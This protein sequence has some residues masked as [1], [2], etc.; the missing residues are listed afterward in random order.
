MK[1]QSIIKFVFAFVCLANVTFALAHDDGEKKIVICSTTQIADFA[2]NV[3]GDRWTVQ[4]VLSAGQ[5]PHN[6]RITTEDSRNVAAADLC[7]ENG[8]NLEGKSWM[9]KLAQQA[10]RPIKTCVEGIKPLDAEEEGGHKVEDPHAWMNATNAW[11]YV[12]N[13]RDAV[14]ELDPTHA[15]E[16]AAR[17]DLFRLQLKSLDVWIKKQ[18]SQIPAN[19]RLLVSHHDA[20]GYFCAAYGFKGISPKGWTTDELAGASTRA[21]QDIVDEVRRLGVKAIFVETSLNPELVTQ[22]AKDAGVSIGGELYSD[23]MG[24]DGTAGESYIGMM[25]ENVLTIVEALK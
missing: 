4:C 20:F 12:Q 16:Y 3:V 6:Y 7:L 25:R 9:R 18:V 2:R 19:E 8:W 24:A 17:A 22:I 10:N 13:I 23:A 5:D 15:D 11:I 14:A 1:F 21:S